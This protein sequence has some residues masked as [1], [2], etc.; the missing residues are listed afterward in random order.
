MMMNPHAPIIGKEYQRTKAR[1]MDGLRDGTATVEEIADGRPYACY[2]CGDH[3][4]GK[5]IGVQDT[6]KVGVS[7]ATTMY[8]LDELCYETAKHGGIPSKPSKQVH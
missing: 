5:I 4:S 6:E 8:A 1:L 7:A 3:I 2:L